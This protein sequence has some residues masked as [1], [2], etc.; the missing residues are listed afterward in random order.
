[1][2]SKGTN[3]VQ[4]GQHVWVTASWGGRLELEVQDYTDPA[5]T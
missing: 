4:I 2:S 1:M 3:P 5:G